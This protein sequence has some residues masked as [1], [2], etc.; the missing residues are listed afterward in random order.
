MDKPP[1]RKCFDQLRFVFLT[2]F[3]FYVSLL[4]LDYYLVVS[5]H[6]IS[7]LLFN[8]N[9]AKHAQM[10]T[11]SSSS[12]N[13]SENIGCPSKTSNQTNQNNGTN[14]ASN[15]PRCAIDKSNVPA[16]HGERNR[17][18]HIS[19]PPLIRGNV[20]LVTKQPT[21][22]LDPCSGQYIYVYDLP[23]RF[24]EDLLKGCNS[25]LKWVDMCPYM[26][27][28]G[29]G[30]KVIEKSNGKVL[31][32][33]SWYKTNQF[34]LEV[35]FHNIMKHYKCL[36]K[37]SSLASAI[38]VP[39]YAGLDV[40]QYLWDFNASVRDASPK[41]LVKWLAQQ[42]EWKRM[43]GRDHFFVGGRIGY[44][45][46]RKTDEDSDWG[47]KLM[48]LPEA[49]NM[50]LLIIESSSYD[51]DFPIPYPTYF[52]PSKD[53][54]VF[55]WQE[56]IRRMKRPYLFSFAGA[57][58]PNSSSS[59]SI[60]NELIKH[61]Q[62]SR[63]CKLLGCYDTHENI[64]EDPVSVIRVFQ[65]SIFCLQPPGDSYTRRS[66]FDSIL[67]GCIPVFFHPKSAYKQYL[68]HFPKKGSSYSVYIPERDVKGDK[69]MINETLSRVS[70][71]EVWA[72]REEVIRLIP[73]IIYRDPRSRLETV[74][75]AFDVAVKGV[76]GRIEAIRSENTSVK[77]YGGGFVSLNNTN[78][79]TAGE[80]DAE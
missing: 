35:I 41:A 73:R 59:Y 76:L 68:W 53:T 30:P 37:N 67:A 63:S 60:R 9:G 10:P 70:H 2:T 6:G 13:S 39:Y 8:V 56:R 31:S 11:P 29:L 71:S 20:E 21:R 64:C 3:V 7:F 54:E 26:T 47:T 61:C 58:R 22:N 4:L 75:D 33:D 79:D 23:S 28:L 69:V 14:G 16:A 72:M 51:N 25:L 1:L 15:I 62:S 48:F 36:T 32:K 43:W 38:F 45:F 19:P 12:L 80:M 55:Q 52:H 57:S 5:D 42:P 77:Y 78:S 27:N 66:T 49:S 24:N 50:S 74:E 18:E 34:S 46:R 17:R 44:D 40:G 65:R